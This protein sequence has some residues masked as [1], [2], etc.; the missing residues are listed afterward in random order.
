MQ[1]QH[2]FNAAAAAAAVSE[3]IAVSSCRVSMKSGGVRVCYCTKIKKSLIFSSTAQQ[4][5]VAVK[6]AEER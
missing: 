2:L 4:T 6:S 5:D 1:W 3:E